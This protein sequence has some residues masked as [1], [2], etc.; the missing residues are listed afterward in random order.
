VSLFRFLVRKWNRLW[1]II[2]LRIVIYGWS[3]LCVVVVSYLDLFA[4]RPRVRLFVP[5]LI[6]VVVVV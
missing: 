4:F 1:I 3:F 6:L 5:L 2:D